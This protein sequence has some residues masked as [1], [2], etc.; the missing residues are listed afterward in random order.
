MT[1]SFL[2]RIKDFLVSLGPRNTIVRLAL[3][4]HGRRNG[5]VIA[6]PNTSIS[7]RRGS[8]EIVLAE[9]EFYNVPFTL[10]CFDQAFEDIEPKPRGTLEV[11]DFSAPGTHRYKRHGITLTFPGMPE[12]DSIA[13]YTQWYTPKPGDLVFDIGAHAGFTTCMFA[14][15]VGP[16]GRVVAFEPD[17]SSFACLERNVGDQQISNVTIV[18][19]AIDAKTGTAYFNADG[20]M[21]AGLV[22][23]LVHGD[24]GRRTAVETLSLEDAC[25][26]FGVPQFVKMDIQ[27]AEIAVIQSAAEFLKAHSMHLA[28][29]SCH[30]MRDG[31]F[32]WM[33]LEPM[34]SSL[35]YEVGSSADS[36]QMVTWARGFFMGID[37]T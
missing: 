33:L 34:L 15:M 31:R 6:F 14:R 1:T 26:Q 16:S 13:A 4:L 22:E 7:I 18:R 12:D 36:G 37:A 27:G 21:A 23:Y 30:R 3:R 19:K 17:A 29:D 9:K 24:T 35:G 11:L 25:G 10:E 20:T 32:T 28:F 2:Q 8:R 5:F